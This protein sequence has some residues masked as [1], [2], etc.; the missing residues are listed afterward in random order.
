MNTAKIMG[1]FE[2]G[3][4]TLFQIP[5]VEQERFIKKLGIPKSDWDRSFKQ[6]CCIEYFSNWQRLFILNCSAIVLIIV[7]IPYSFVRFIFNQ[8]VDDIKL[9][10][11]G[12][13][14]GLTEII[15][16]SLAADYDIN[17]DYWFKGA[18]L[19]PSDLSYIIKLCLCYFFHPYFLFKN[20]A[21]IARYSYMINHYNPRAIIVHDE[22]SFTSSLLTDYCERRHVQHINVMHGEKF[23][24]IGTGY[25]RFH[26]CYAWAEHYVNLF[27]ELY[28]DEQQFIIELPPSLK[29]DVHKNY[30]QSAYADYKYY[31]Q[32]YDENQLKGIVNSMNEIRKK[33]FSISYRPH[34]RFSNIDLLKKYVPKE[35]IENPSLV[36]IETSISSTKH[37]ISGF[38]TV[39]NQAFYAG[40]DI[41]FDDVTYNDIYL[42]LKEYRYI[43]S[44]YSLN[45]LSTIINNHSNENKNFS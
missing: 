11:I 26:K 44:E 42:K 12:E 6:Y 29:I 40:K 25:F 45:T 20:I 35:Y 38:S 2:W 16:E 21:K 41:L 15:P 14:K 19:S 18:E 8:R 22:Y 23:Y 5:Q 39:M 7:Y 28:A 31:L 43:L 10:A 17:N 30:S 32:I 36:N 27:K 37:V 4:K 34:P 24:T 33:G 9:D 3:R 1:L 13:F